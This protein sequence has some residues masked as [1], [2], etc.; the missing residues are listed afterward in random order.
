M[1]ALGLSLA[2][3]NVIPYPGTFCMHSLCC[4]S[5]NGNL[6]PIRGAN[7]VLYRP[8]VFIRAASSGFL[9]AVESRAKLHLDISD[10]HTIARL[11]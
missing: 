3:Y 8:V 1:R 11:F 4:G 10:K 6:L 5:I 7:T 2:V 9:W